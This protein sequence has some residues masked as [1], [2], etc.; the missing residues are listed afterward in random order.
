MTKKRVGLRELAGLLHGVIHKQSGLIQALKGDP[1]PSVHNLRQRA[2]AKR[3]LAESVL[4]YL[5]GDRTMLTIEAKQEA[6]SDD[7]A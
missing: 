1:N 5:D 4:D 3:D 7:A 6:T 2:I